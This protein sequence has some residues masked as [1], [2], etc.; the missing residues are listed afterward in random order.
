MG[1]FEEIIIFHL[2][3][4]H[5]L[6]TT[7]QKSNKNE[8]TFILFF[9]I[10]VTVYMFDNISR[11]SCSIAILVLEPLYIIE[12]MFRSDI[13]KPLNIHCRVREAGDPKGNK[14]VGMFVCV[15][16]FA[17][18]VLLCHFVEFVS[19]YRVGKKG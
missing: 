14:L 12:I 3:E 19:I 17:W 16:V 2:S 9:V 11:P 15:C 5:V 8:M 1:K 18:S 10:F 7:L 13:E 4:I 6:K